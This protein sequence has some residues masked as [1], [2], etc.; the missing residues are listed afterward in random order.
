M[1]E[2]DVLSSVQPAMEAFSEKEVLPGVFLTDYRK[3]PTEPVILDSPIVA[4]LKG[5]D[6]V[7]TEE[8]G[9]YPIGKVERKIADGVYMT[10]FRDTSKIAQQNR[11]TSFGASVFG[12]LSQYDHPEITDA[13]VNELLNSIKHLERSNQELEEFKLTDPDPIWQE[14]IDENIG[15]INRQ[16]AEIQRLQ[17]SKPIDMTRRS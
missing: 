1:A 17:E 3:P 14:T 11:T 15:V 13:R 12:S 4:E 2:K 8:E 10:D 5:L 7:E 16:R 9:S 6:F